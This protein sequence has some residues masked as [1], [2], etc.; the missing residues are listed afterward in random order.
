VELV[1]VTVNVEAFPAVIDAGFAD[2]LTVGAEGGT[3]V[4]VV[5][6]V[7]FPPAPVAAAV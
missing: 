7:A 5:V 4:T 2:M 3:T 6:A 1:A